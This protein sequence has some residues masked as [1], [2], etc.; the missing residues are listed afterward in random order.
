MN[1]KT[2]SD[3]DRMQQRSIGEVP[4]ASIGIDSGQGWNFSEQDN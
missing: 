2:V 3:L 1:N 4:Q